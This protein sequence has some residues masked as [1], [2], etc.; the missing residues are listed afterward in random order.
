[1][2]SGES[3]PSHGDSPKEHLLNKS[4]AAESVFRVMQEIFPD[5]INDPDDRTDLPRVYH[6]NESRIGGDGVIGD[7]FCS[8]YQTA[9]PTIDPASPIRYLVNSGSFA[10]L[11]RITVR[12]AALAAIS[13]AAC[14]KTLE[15][16]MSDFKDGNPNDVPD[17][18]KGQMQ[19]H[20]IQMKAIQQNRDEIPDP[21]EGQPGGGS[22]EDDDN[23]EMPQQDPLG[24]SG[25]SGGGEGPSQRPNIIRESSIK[26]KLMARMIEQKNLLEIFKLIG[27][28]SEI[29]T[30]IR[31]E[32]LFHAPGSSE[33]DMG[34]D[35]SRL[36]LQETL[37]P[38]EMLARDLAQE[39]AWMNVH[40][41][42]GA[43]GLGPLAICIDQSG[44][45]NCSIPGD[46]EADRSDVA[47]ALALALNKICK[48]Q[49]R[50]M[51]VVGFDSTVNFAF[52]CPNGLMAPDD[53]NTL[54][55]G[56]AWGG[57]GFKSP[58]NECRDWIKKHE[59]EGKADI[60][61]VTDGCAGDS[62]GG[63]Y[64]PRE[65]KDYDSYESGPYTWV[66]YFEDHDHECDLDPDCKI[67][68]RPQLAEN[69][70]GDKKPDAYRIDDQIKWYNEY[71]R[72]LHDNDVRFWIL[73]LEQT[74]IDRPL[75]HLSD[76]TFVGLE[77]T[78]RMEGATRSLFTEMIENRKPNWL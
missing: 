24:G 52:D 15:F 5:L 33:L 2:V 39:S 28:M 25:G 57:T 18:M 7:T 36:T 44:S 4:P 61:F 16:Y 71:H 59:Y 8:L 30:E 1:M 46:T 29:E 74:F 12:D 77:D 78:A 56:G 35:L 54:I 22:G 53:L 68:Y 49:K 51:L 41:D 27:Q 63:E 42:G 14:L 73:H 21:A 11:R 38:T 19:E 40:K 13:T 23:N 75:A 34:S 31:N 67:C 69:Y 65:P 6:L 10:E 58:L 62:F 32:N 43:K 72:F 9:P 50:H 66:K 20:V 17:A 55:S 47:T 37:K 64:H 70:S 45:M 76:K 60:I 26:L 3:F 48:E